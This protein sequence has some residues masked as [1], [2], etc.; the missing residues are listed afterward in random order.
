MSNRPLYLQ[1]WFDE[2]LKDTELQPSTRKTYTSWFRKFHAF[3]VNDLHIAEPM[4]SDL[5]ED[6]LR[7]YLRYTKSRPCEKP[8]IFHE[9]PTKLP[10]VDSNTVRSAFYVI[11]ALCEYLIERRVI[12]DNPYKLLNLP[13]RK[14]N[15]GLRPEAQ[16][17]DIVQVLQAASTNPDPADRALNLA[18]LWTLIDSCMRVT[19]LTNMTLAGLDLARREAKVRDKGDKTV[20]YAFSDT[21]ADAIAAWLAYR[22]KNCKHNFVFCRGPEMKVGADGVRKYIRE[23]CGSLGI[24]YR[25]ILP[26]SLRH[27]GADR[28]QKSGVQIGTIQSRLGHKR[29]ETT[30]RYLQAGKDKAS[31]DASKS[32]SLANSMNLAAVQAPKPYDRPADAPRV[33]T[34]T[35]LQKAQTAHDFARQ[36]RRRSA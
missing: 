3:L 28:L 20:T 11:R 35:M 7:E 22:P 13:K 6:N 16:D 17:A 29:L 27:A 24:D 31:I 19:A 34:R 33:I 4:I 18:M 32:V 10:I 30:V 36:R 12:T 21:T 5:T 15:Q 9:D 26:H 23:L 8:S 25:T 2:Y 1:F 14:Y